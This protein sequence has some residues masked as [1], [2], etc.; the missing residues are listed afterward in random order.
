M[1]IPTSARTSPIF[2]VCPNCDFHRRIRALDYINILL[3]DGSI[4][5]TE[6][7]LRRSTRSPF[8]NIPRA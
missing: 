5:E 6:A 8:P 1:A 7:D 2:N 4:E 3:D